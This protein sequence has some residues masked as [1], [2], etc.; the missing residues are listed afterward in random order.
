[1]FCKEVE[2]RGVP[3]RALGFAPGAAGYPG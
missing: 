1:M 2:R 3:A